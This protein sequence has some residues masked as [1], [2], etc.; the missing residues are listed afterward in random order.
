[1]FGGSGFLGRRVVAR[2]V[3]GGAHVRIAV[4]HPERARFLEELGDAGQVSCVAADVWDEASVAG[5]IGE[6]ASV[7]NC[8]GH[9]LE[10]GGASFDAV[11]GQGALHVA[12]QAR[13]AGVGR[14]VHISGIGAD[15]ASASPYVRARA[16]GEWLVAEAFPGATI[17]RP[18][19]IFGPEDKFFNMLAGVAR[20]AP[21][22]ALFG[23]GATRLQPVFVDDVAEACARVLADPAT[24]GRT[25][26]LGGPEVLTYRQVL[27]LV[28]R[29]TGRRRLLVP[30]PFAL[31]EV[32][33]ALAALLPTPPLTRDQITLMR[34]DNV[35][36]DEAL[37]FQDLGMR[38]KAVADVVPGYIG[39]T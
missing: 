22:L 19:V 4:R 2:L 21:V 10:K 27:S 29:W 28:L 14:L 37:S 26:E 6:S 1:M 30:V 36:A 25:Y 33:A 23:S 12:R 7:I 31:W 13:A 38:A 8:V 39:G 24:A 34:D 3:D 32:L 5:A 16:A 35:V 9:Y 18:S 11:H 15:A 20:V 17:L